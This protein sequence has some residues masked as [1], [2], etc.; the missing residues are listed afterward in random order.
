M[1]TETLFRRIGDYANRADPYPLY[2]ELRES[3]VARQEDGSY[4]VGTYHEIA[5]LLHDPRISS[6]RRNRTDPDKGLPPTGNLPPAFI[7]LD[8]PE[9]ERLRR[10]VMRP[11]GPPH[12]PGRIDALHDDITRIAEEL[13]GAFRDKDRIDLVDDFAFPLP[14]TVIC[15]LLGVPDDDVPRIHTWADTIV[16]SLD[17]AP[18]EDPAPRQDAAQEARV[19]MGMYLG[20]LAEE[21]RGHPTGDMLSAL[22]GGEGSQRG[23]TQL[24]LMSS[25]VLLLIAGHETTVNLITNGMLTLLRNPDALERLRNEPELMP[26]AVEEL[27]RYEPPVQFLPQRT[28]LADVEV[29]G[30]TIPKGAPLI[31]VLA[32]GNRDPL[33]FP[34]PDRFDPA[35]EDNQ[36]FGF[37]S[38]VH[39]CFGAPLARIE[40]QIA[41][42]TLL[43]HLDSPRLLED[44]PPY[45]RSPVLR[46]P[47]HL[48]LA[49]T[50]GLR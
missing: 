1:S 47:R 27:L 18:G 23:L 45:R 7:S 26:G 43:R 39:S 4:L 50:P 32:S 40:T 19:A 17:P 24:E 29:A 16:E 25:M 20:E 41:L 21:R 9:H 42:T 14:V 30:V 33:R 36:H 5:A 37:G 34:E 38:G 11:F 3:K 46:G 35:R 15:R 49:P 2:A 8:D 10:L 28:P 22:A 6:D 31:L 44:P 13:A 12:S 48:P